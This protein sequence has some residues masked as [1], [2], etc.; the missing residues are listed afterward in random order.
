MRMI[1]SD[2]L[3][4]ISLF[5]IS[6]GVFGMFRYK[7]FYARILIASDIDTVGFL[8]LM[9]GVIIRSGFSWFSAKV[10]LIIIIVMLINPVVTHS[11]ARSAHHSGYRIEEEDDND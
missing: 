10:L 3:I 8:L 4:V 5:F 7:N 11:I 2:I 1:I 6:I 9:A